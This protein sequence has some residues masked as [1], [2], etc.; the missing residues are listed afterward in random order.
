MTKT[1]YVKLGVGVDPG[2]FGPE[3]RGSGRSQG[4][5]TAVTQTRSERKNGLRA[6]VMWHGLL[7]H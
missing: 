4:L 6:R 7:P 5:L 1:S 2:G 3:T